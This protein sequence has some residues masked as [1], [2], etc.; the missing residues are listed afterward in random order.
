MVLCRLVRRSTFSPS[1]LEK[2]PKVIIIF[3]QDLMIFGCQHSLDRE[4]H[5]PKKWFGS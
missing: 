5:G 2:M 4:Q 1:N 3:K